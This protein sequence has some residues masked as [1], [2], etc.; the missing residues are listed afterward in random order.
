MSLTIDELTEMH[1]LSVRSVNVCK[2]NDLYTLDELLKYY[3]DHQTF[4]E[5][6]NC[7]EKS[8]KELSG[9]CKYY[10]RELQ[11]SVPANAITHVVSESWDPLKTEVVVRY[12]KSAFSRLSVRAINGLEA[13]HLHEIDLAW[14]RKLPELDFSGIKNIG[15]KTEKELVQ[16]QRDI[17]A[18]QRQ[19]G[20][21]AGSDL[22]QTYLKML[23]TSTFPELAADETLDM[24]VFFTTEGK[25]RLFVLIMH[26]LENGILFSPSRSSLFLDFYTGSR[27]PNLSL[28]ADKQGLTRERIRQ[29]RIAFQED[30]DQYFGFLATF[31]ANDLADTVFKDGA[32]VLVIAKAW[33]QQM[34]ASANLRFSGQFYAQTLSLIFR[35]SYDLIEYTVQAGQKHTCYALIERRLNRVY[36]FQAWLSDL[37]ALLQ[38]RIAEDYELHFE[39]YLA[40]F[41]KGEFP[42]E[43]L[44]PVKMVCTELL[45]ECFEL[46][47]GEEGFL[48]IQQNVRKTMD[49]YILQALNA[50]GDPAHLDQIVF[51]LETMFPDQAW[52][53]SSVR[54][55]MLREKDLFICISRTSTFGLRTWEVEREN[56]RGGTIRDMVENY[57]EDELL[58]KHISE[59][60]HYVNQFRN[61]TESSLITNLEAEENA[62]F[63]IFPGEFIGLSAKNYEGLPSYK[64]LNGVHF[65]GIQLKKMN[66]WPFDAVVGHFVEKFGYLPIQVAYILNKRIAGGDLILTDDNRISL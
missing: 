27:P 29:L 54:G 1:W 66:Q 33:V 63:R 48:L 18:F 5:L 56:L 2:S 59:V 26:L 19:I 22:R 4:K 37:D 51:Q 10:E 32:T 14:L 60:L 6:R 7:G 12:A 28:V 39:G 13:E 64:R 21:M 23:I 62:R 8:S 42:L 11:S 9:I 55:T 24:T 17:Q 61:T 47:V 65:T 53:E 15:R 35:P 40:G 52:N 38:D 36:D 57:L 45:F 25:I 58:P 16:F 49:E 44:G 20:P 43:M 34:N 46:A 3:K 41:F 50:L 30:F 31:E